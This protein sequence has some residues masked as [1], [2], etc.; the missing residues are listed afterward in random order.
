M[1]KQPQQTAQEH[2]VESLSR[3]TEEANL[4]LAQVDGEC[5]DARLSPRQQDYL[6]ELLLGRD[7][8]VAESLRRLLER[9]RP[10]LKVVPAPRHGEE[11]AGHADDL[12]T[13]EGDPTTHAFWYG[14]SMR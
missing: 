1:R 3:I 12:A 7:D 5:L 4:A 9:G 6:R 2:L 13:R 14:A 11:D 8:E 10:H